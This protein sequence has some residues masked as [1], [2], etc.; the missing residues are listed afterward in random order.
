MLHMK[1]AGVWHLPR[2][3]EY[4]PLHVMLDLTLSECETL[5]VMASQCTGGV[6][7]LVTHAIREMIG[8][9]FTPLDAVK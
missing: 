1:A 7:E 9:E 6:N 8:K 2:T 4:N 5:E 3:T